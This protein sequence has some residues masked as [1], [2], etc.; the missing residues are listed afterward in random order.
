LANHGPALDQIA[1][2]QV[3]ATG[4]DKG[5]VNAESAFIW[6]R[7]CDHRAYVYG[8]RLNPGLLSGERSTRPDAVRSAGKR[9]AVLYE[10]GR[11]GAAALDL[12]GRLVGDDGSAL[13]VVGLAPQDTRIRCGAG[14]AIDY[15]RAVCEA[16]DAE[17]RQARELL[18]DAGN[19]A[20]FT[21]LAQDRDPPLSAWIDGGGFDVV[22][23]PARRRPLRGTKHPAADQLRRSTSAEVRIVEAR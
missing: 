21:L 20:S 19:R 23:L 5:E 22:L 8:E 11:T 9:V 4:H 15:N 12:A 17:L 3:H 14:S 13:A 10:P 7:T 6:R 16:V 2:H 1:S 18:G